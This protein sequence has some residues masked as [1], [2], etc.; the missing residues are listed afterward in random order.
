MAETLTMKEIVQK[1]M[2]DLPEHDTIDVAMERLYFLWKIEEGTRDLDNG[3]TYTTEQVE[4]MLE[5][6][7]N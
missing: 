2:E 7:L 5:S 4:Q 3:R 1:A 6:H